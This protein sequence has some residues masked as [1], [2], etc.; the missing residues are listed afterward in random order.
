[1]KKRS[2]IVMITSL[3]VAGA[4]AFALCAYA[5]Y[6]FIAFLSGGYNNLMYKYLSN[7][8]NYKEFSLHYKTAYY[9][10]RDT[11]KQVAIDANTTANDI[12]YNVYLV[13]YVNSDND[14]QASEM[15]FELCNANARALVTNGLFDDISQGDEIRLRATQWI[16]MDNDFM[17][18]ADVEYAGKHYLNLEQGLANI[19]KEMDDHRIYG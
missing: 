12:K 18:I 10:D 16:Y 9:Y 11:R 2:K 4:V 7:A 3:S 13:C 17:F 6:C 15:R 1:M 5:L 14:E 8:D 19:V